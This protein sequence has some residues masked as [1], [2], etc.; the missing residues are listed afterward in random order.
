MPKEKTHRKKKKHAHPLTVAR[1]QS[2]LRKASRELKRAK[3]RAKRAKK[4]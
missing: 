3:L 2:Q 1:A 4:K